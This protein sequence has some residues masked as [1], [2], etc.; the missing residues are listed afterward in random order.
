M[1]RGILT[2]NVI[3]QQ[4][5]PVNNSEGLP[6]Q[7]GAD[8]LDSLWWLRERRPCGNAENA[9]NAGNSESGDLSDEACCHI[10][11]FAD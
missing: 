7:L 5:T 10:R 2:T 9:G 6:A 1:A 4:R 11:T 8:S 3:E